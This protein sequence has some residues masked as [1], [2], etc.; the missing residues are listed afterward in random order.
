M[1]GGWFIKQKCRKGEE[2][3]EMWGRMY[4]SIGFLMFML[5]K[6]MEREHST[7][8]KAGFLN[9]VEGVDVG[10]ILSVGLGVFWSQ[11]WTRTVISRVLR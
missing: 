7:G 4:N 2:G 8:L 5:Y 11:S 1:D 9:G 10:V 6:Q 3:R